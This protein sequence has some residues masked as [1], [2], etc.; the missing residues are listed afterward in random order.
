[1]LDISRA[2][3]HV[4]QHRLQY[5]FRKRHFKLQL[6]DL[7]ILFLFSQVTT[8]QSNEFTL[9]KLSITCSIS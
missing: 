2:Y 6:V 7:I 4:C 8:I 1:M 9:A 3:K 5:N